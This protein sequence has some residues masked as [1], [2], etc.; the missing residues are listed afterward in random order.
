MDIIAFLVNKEKLNKK[1]GILL[2]T[3][4]LFWGIFGTIFWDTIK[5]I[6]EWKIEEV[7]L[8]VVFLLLFWWLT[9]Y[10]SKQIK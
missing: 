2:A 10:L 5:K 6:G 8:Y 7:W 4:W 1:R 9:I 3:L